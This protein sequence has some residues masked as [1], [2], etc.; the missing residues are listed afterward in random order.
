MLGRKPILHQT[1]DGVELKR[2]GH[3]KEWLPLESFSLE[4]RRWDGLAN[5]CRSCGAS[6]DRASYTVHLEERR[7]TDKAYRVAHIEERHAS[8]RAWRLAHLEKCRAAVQAWASVHL[9]ERRVNWERRRARELAAPGADYTTAQH[10]RDR[11]AMF[12]DR[13]WICGALATATDHVKPLAKGGAHWPCNLRPVCRSCNSAKK[14]HWPFS[15]EDLR[16]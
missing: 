1:V 13:C 12:G 9:V 3:C 6:K 4:R 5:C 16:I 14:D 7:A 10:I 11:W 2:C 15:K 8:Y